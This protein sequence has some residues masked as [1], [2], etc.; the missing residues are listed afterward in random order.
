MTGTEKGK[1]KNV[2]KRLA[3]IN[4][5][6]PFKFHLLSEV[7]AKL[8]K[9]T[10]IVMQMDTV[11]C[12]CV[13]VCVWRCLQVTAVMNLYDL[14]LKFWLKNL[15]A[16]VL[17][18]TC[19]L[20]YALHSQLKHMAIWFFLNTYLF[21][22]L[23]EE[24]KRKKEKKKLS[25]NILCNKLQPDCN[26]LELSAVCANTVN[27]FR[28]IISANRSYQITSNAVPLLCQH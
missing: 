11:H 10:R 25:T 6:I 27:S 12:V 16:R 26:G 2:I 18:P 19:T 13:C 14:L 8:Y 24:K 23:K 3:S 9:C 15:Q 20:N 17:H 7:S 22:F 4:T 1:A 21:I 5:T 28:T